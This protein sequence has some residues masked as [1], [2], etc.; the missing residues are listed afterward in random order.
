MSTQQNENQRKAGQREFRSEKISTRSRSGS[1][2]KK[3]NPEEEE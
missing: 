1:T 2:K 3:S